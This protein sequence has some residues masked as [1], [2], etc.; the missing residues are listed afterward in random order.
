VSDPAPSHVELL[1]LSGFRNHRETH[2]EPGRAP[3]VLLTG[4]NGAGKTNILEALSL[5]S[6]GRGLRNAPLS[7]MAAKDGEGGFAVAARVSTDPGLPPLLV[8]TGTL[9]ARPER[10]RLSINGAAAPLAELG[11]WLSVLWVTPAMD[12]LFAD[13]AS[14]RRRFLDRLALALTPGHARHAGRY[15]AAMRARNRLLAADVPPDPD[16][17]AALEAEMAEH[18]AAVRTARAETV[19]LLGQYLDGLAAGPFPQPRL[20]LAGDAVAGLAARL[21]ASRAADRAA[22]RATSGPHRDDLVVV[23]ADKDMPAA[24]ASTGE[25]KAL[26]L[27]IVLAHAGLV[28]ERTGRVPLLLLDEAAAH[29]DAERRAALLERLLSLGGQ[30]W[31][32]GTDAGLFA[33][34]GGTMARY[35]I[36]DGNAGTSAAAA[37][38]GGHGTA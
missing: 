9:A 32:S 25:Q 4:A 29:L 10:R 13:T 17:L 24:L 36:A 15:E 11:A 37:G 26:L 35:D 3:I 33:A 12:R 27:A 34:T 1:H 28:A 16:W 8:R 6:V 23:H 18:G 19:A 22:G 38:C 5:L 14:A 21:A 7:A 30:S 31:L 20:A 2:L